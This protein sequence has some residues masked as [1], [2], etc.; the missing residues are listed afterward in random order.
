MIIGSD[1][2]LD[3]AGAWDRSSVH[4]IMN[5]F[6][7]HKIYKYIYMYKIYVS[8]YIVNFISNCAGWRKPSSVKLQAYLR[9]PFWLKV[10]LRWVGVESAWAIGR[11]LPFDIL[12]RTADTSVWHRSTVRIIHLG[13]AV[14]SDIRI[15]S[16]GIGVKTSSLSAAG[17]R[18]VG[19]D[20]CQYWFHS[21]W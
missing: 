21:Y 12:L 13:S 3:R 18:I 19:R 16:V 1:L 15:S 17:R 6:L 9:Q 8:M 14:V 7:L 20:C 11:G 10:S 2:T 4:M 5:V